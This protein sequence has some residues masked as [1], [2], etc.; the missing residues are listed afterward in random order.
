M[1]APVPSA[2]PA[3]LERARDRY[4]VLRNAQQCATRRAF[5]RFAADLI[6]HRILDRLQSLEAAAAAERL[7]LGGDNP[8]EWWP[9]GIAY[10]PPVAAAGELESVLVALKRRLRQLV[11]DLASSLA[12]DQSIRAMCNASCG[13]LSINNLYSQLHY[14]V[15]RYFKSLCE[16]H[17]ANCNGIPFGGIDGTVSTVKNCIASIE[18]MRAPVGASIAPGARPEKEAERAALNARVAAPLAPP[19]YVP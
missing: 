17:V 2:P 12:F 11:D 7:A 4:T 8:A 9:A 6:E 3:E 14:D 15:C 19:P 1:A 18:K 16:Y 10:T 13:R 5:E